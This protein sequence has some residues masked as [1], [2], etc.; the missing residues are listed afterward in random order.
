MDTVDYKSL[1]RSITKRGTQLK[2]TKACL[3]MA[4]TLLQKVKGRAK[5]PEDIFSVCEA[6]HSVHLDYVQVM[7]EVNKHKRSDKFGKLKPSGFWQY[8][9]ENVPTT[10]EYYNQWHRI[11]TGRKITKTEFE[12]KYKS[13]PEAVVKSI[14]SLGDT[15]AKHWSRN[16]IHANDDYLVD[17]ADVVTESE[18]KYVIEFKNKIDGYNSRV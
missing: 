14:I 11:H 2:Y 17:L 16:K 5:N 10:Y 12:D 13:K 4:K 7:Q 8:M 1:A 15:M 3:N 18:R 6:V 9:K